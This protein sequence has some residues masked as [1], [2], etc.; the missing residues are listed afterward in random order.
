[1]SKS[2]TGTR[3]QG[4]WGHGDMGTRGLGDSGTWGRGDLG[5]WG[6]WDVRTLRHIFEV[7]VQNFRNGRTSP[8]KLNCLWYFAKMINC[9]LFKY[10]LNTQ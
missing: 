2:G 7:H 3:G 6:C 4:T 5:T 10:H 1:M 8:R 9:M